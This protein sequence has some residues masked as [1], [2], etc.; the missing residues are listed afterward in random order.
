MVPPKLP[1][2][3]ADADADADATA[4]ADADADADAN[5]SR[6]MPWASPRGQ[7]PGFSLIG[8][9]DYASPKNVILAPAYQ[10]VTI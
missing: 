9:W 4:D 5:A 7:Y 2:S 1:S 10:N 6:S 3:D 8:I